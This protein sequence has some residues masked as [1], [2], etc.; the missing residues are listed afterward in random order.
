MKCIGISGK[1]RSGKDTFFNILHKYNPEYKNI[2]FADK[3]KTI[4]SL[5]TGYPIEYFYNGDMYDTYLPSW[6]MTIRQFMQKLG[7]ETFRDGFDQ[8][9]WV[10]SLQDNINENDCVVIT[11]VRF[12][13]EAGWVKTNGILIRINRNYKVFDKDTHRSEIELD[14]YNDFDYVIDNNS[15]YENYINQIQEVLKQIGLN[16]K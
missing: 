16:W 9:V 8:N 11:D 3:L 14:N 2:K 1:K 6:G 7:T 15:T 10:K 13:N 4:C 5:I 12:L